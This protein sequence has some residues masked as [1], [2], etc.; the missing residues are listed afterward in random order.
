MILLTGSYGR[1]GKQHHKSL[2]NTVSELCSS[3]FPPLSSKAGGARVLKRQRSGAR[4][5]KE[6]ILGK[7]ERHLPPSVDV[8][9]YTDAKNLQALN[10]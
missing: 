9:P 7:N 6:T 8:M 5:I 4:V 1:N 10:K 3:P 2:P